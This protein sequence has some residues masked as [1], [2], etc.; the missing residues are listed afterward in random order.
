MLLGKDIFNILSVH[1]AVVFV[2]LIVITEP[3]VNL[4]VFGVYVVDK[5]PSMKMPNFDKSIST[6]PVFLI[7]AF[8]QVE[9]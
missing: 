3:G 7:V 5:T 6:V 8:T 1:A 9:G 4:L 2:M